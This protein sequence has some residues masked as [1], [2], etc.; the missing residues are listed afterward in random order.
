MHPFLRN[1]KEVG[2]PLQEASQWEMATKGAYWGG[3]P[4]PKNVEKKVKVILPPATL[5]IY[6]MISNDKQITFDVK[7]AIWNK[8]VDISHFGRSW[9]LNNYLD[10]SN[11]PILAD[12]IFLP[13]SAQTP[14]SAGMS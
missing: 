3:V 7:W 10:Q 14:P 1:G 11:H 6:H 2:V 13:S 12:N 9:C 4:P 5:L 8:F